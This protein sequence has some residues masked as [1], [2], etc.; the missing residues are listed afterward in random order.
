MRRQFFKIAIRQIRDD[1]LESFERRQPTDIALLD[2]GNE[3]IRVTVKIKRR[4]FEAGAAQLK[5][6][7]AAAGGRLQHPA[8]D[9][10]RSQQRRHNPMRVD[11]QI[12]VAL[13]A[14]IAGRRDVGAALRRRRLAR[15]DG[16][17]EGAVT[18]IRSLRFASRLGTR[19]RSG[20]PRRNGRANQ[21]S[22]KPFF[23]G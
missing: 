18:F 15:R 7:M 17:E 11:S 16:R 10:S 8:L 2:V 5:R 13:D 19:S 21:G 14:L 23:R 20:F 3:R 12:A 22:E 6:Q 1:P 9:R 4:D